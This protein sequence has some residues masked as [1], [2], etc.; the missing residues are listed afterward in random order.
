VLVPGAIAATSAEIRMKKPADAARAPGGLTKTTTGTGEV[1][2]AVVM[3]RVVSTSPPGVSNSI[4]TNTASRSTASASARSMNCCDAGWIVSSTRIRT[5]SPL[6]TGAATASVN[7][8]TSHMRCRC[9]PKMIGPI[10][11]QDKGFHSSATNF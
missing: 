11:L 6:K 3:S 1:V 7:T 9:I 8:T 5:T 2:M 10:D 4:T